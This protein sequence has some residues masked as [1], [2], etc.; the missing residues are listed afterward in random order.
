MKKQIKSYIPKN[1]YANWDLD[2][3]AQGYERNIDVGPT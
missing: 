3:I 2:S 1:I